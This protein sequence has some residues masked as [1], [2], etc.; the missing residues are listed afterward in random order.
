M[1]C[2]ARA[3]GVALVRSWLGLGSVGVVC[4]GGDGVEMVWVGLGMRGFVASCVY[5][6]ARTNCSEERNGEAI[7][8]MDAQAFEVETPAVASKPIKLL[9]AVVSLVLGIPHK[10]NRR[11]TKRI[12]LD[13]VAA[14]SY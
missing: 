10:R 13:I 6:C 9:S 14:L 4:G 11:R 7:G 3:P 5:D 12:L 8:H 2:R 1:G